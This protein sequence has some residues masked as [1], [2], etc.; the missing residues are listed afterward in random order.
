MNIA[1]YLLR[2]KSLN[3]PLFVLNNSEAL[4][5]ETDDQWRLEELRKNKDK[6]NTVEPG[7]HIY[8]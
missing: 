2:N 3:P 5:L 1:K 7:K 6:S 8:Q 4:T